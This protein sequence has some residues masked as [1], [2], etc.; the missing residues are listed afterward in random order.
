MPTRL[1]R[2]DFAAEAGKLLKD[3]A[4]STADVGISIVRLADKSSDCESVFRHQSDIPLIPASNLKVLTTSTAIDVLGKDFEFATT[5]IQIGD[6]IGLIG[7]GD[8]SFGDTELLKKF[9]QSSTSTF[10]SWAAGLKARGILKVKDVVVDDSIFTDAFLHKNWSAK[11]S[12]LRYEAEVAGININANCLDF[13]IEPKVRG[14]RVDYRLDPPTAYAPIKNDCVGGLENAVWLSREGEKN[15]VILKG[16]IDR[17]NEE[18]ISVTIHDPP[19]LAGTVLAESLKRAGIKVEGVLRRDSGL[20]K[21][22][23][24]KVL[25]VHKTKLATVLARANKDSMNLY[26]EAMCKRSGAEGGKGGSW[27]T[28]HLA[29]A[30]FLRKCGVRADQFQLDDGCGLSRENRIAA[31]AMTAV[32]IHNYTSPAKELFL[33]SLAV[34]G[35]DGTLE[36]RFHDDLKGRVFAKSGFINRVSCLSGYVHTKHDKWYAFSIL[37]NDVTSGDAKKVQERIVALVDRMEP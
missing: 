5:L 22:R 12:H 10:D 26:A 28:G 29:M 18:P 2:A 15:D 3:K 23:D 34:G 32:L 7:D 21:K 37:M 4:V 25:A 36:K 14:D 13:Y 6:D 30:T 11:Q 27:E 20:M 24:A 16:Q 1:A 33:P 9:G 19:M 17:A 31:G 35:V 8:P